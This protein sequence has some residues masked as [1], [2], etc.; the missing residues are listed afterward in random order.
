MNSN[1]INLQRC[2]VNPY[3]CSDKPN[4]NF[5][6]EIDCNHKQS[7]EITR[8]KTGVLVNLDNLWFI[9]D[10]KT[11]IQIEVIKK[12]QNNFN[13]QDNYF[14]RRTYY[15]ID[16][17]A[18]ICDKK[19]N[20]QVEITQPIQEDIWGEAHIEFSKYCENFDKYNNRTYQDF[21]EWAKKN[22]YTLTKK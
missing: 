19:S 5:G 7:I 1:Y 3:G 15:I 21:F 2:A 13:K 4:N 9:A 10:D 14:D 6:G 20:V 22:N 17:Y 11:N 12:Q 18:C 16:G 8:Y